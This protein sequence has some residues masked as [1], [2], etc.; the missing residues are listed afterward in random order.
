MSIKCELRSIP[1]SSLSPSSEER[2][3]RYLKS[4]F[5]SVTGFGSSHWVVGCY[6]DLDHR[7]YPDLNVDDFVNECVN[8]LNR[9]PER[10]KFQRKLKSPLYGNLEIYSYKLVESNE[11]GFI[12]LELITDVQKTK[13]FWGEGMKLEQPR[14]RRLRKD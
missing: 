13:Y 8:Y 10:E 4:M 1:K 14:R 5:P 9:P 7:N 6:I 2:H 3:G 12:Q 11:S